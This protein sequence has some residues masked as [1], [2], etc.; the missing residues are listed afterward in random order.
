MNFSVLFRIKDIEYLYIYKDV[1]AQNVL[2]KKFLVHCLSCRGFSWGRRP[3]IFADHWT[4][5]DL[6]V[7]W[8]KSITIIYFFLTEIIFRKK[9]VSLSNNDRFDNDKIFLC[10]IWHFLVRFYIFRIYLK[11]TWKNFLVNIWTI[12]CC[13]MQ[14]LIYVSQTKILNEIDCV[15]RTIRTF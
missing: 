3:A 11:V 6:K 4:T 1:R 2:F 10:N 7:A 13:E 8:H 12:S 5:N 15:S 9:M 14:R